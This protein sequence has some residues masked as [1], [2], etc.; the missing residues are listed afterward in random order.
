MHCEDCILN[1]YC[2]YDVVLRYNTLGEPSCTI[3]ASPWRMVGDGLR[4]HFLRGDDA[5]FRFG[6]SPEVISAA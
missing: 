3:A 6:H 5:K 1:S 4:G 2:S